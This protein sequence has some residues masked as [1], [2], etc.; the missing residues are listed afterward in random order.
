MVYNF[1]NA[2]R[3]FNQKRYVDETASTETLLN[4]E[5]KVDDEEHLV[6][7]RTKN[8]ITTTVAVPYALLFILTIYAM[9][10]R[11]QITTNP[12]RYAQTLFS[13]AQDALKPKIEIFEQG[14]GREATPYQGQ[15]SPELDTRWEAL[16]KCKSTYLVGGQV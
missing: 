15:P 8:R 2:M 3:L 5:R 11:N 7:P 10:L 9:I 16:Y 1:H 4:E 14:F 6:I 12:A 13:P